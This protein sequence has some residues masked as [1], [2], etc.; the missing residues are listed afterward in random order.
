MKMRKGH[1][2]GKVI[3]GKHKITEKLHVS[4]QKKQIVGVESS[5]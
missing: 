3:L 2:C 4:E 1:H 5:D